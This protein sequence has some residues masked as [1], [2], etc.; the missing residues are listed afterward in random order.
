MFKL[1][2]PPAALK[3]Q[4]KCFFNNPHF[5]RLLFFSLYI[6]TETSSFAI[7]MDALL[8]F[9]LGWEVQLCSFVLFCIINVDFV[10]VLK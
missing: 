6:V 7:P 3:K 10:I 9:F 1:S 8:I 5:L 4:G 2:S